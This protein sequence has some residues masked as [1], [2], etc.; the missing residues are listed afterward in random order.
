MEHIDTPPTFYAPADGGRN[1][2]FVGN[3]GHDREGLSTLRGDH[4]D[5]LSGGLTVAVDREHARAL[6]REK[7]SGGAAVSDGGA[8]R[9]SRADDDRD[10]V[11]KPHN[12]AFTLEIPG[13]MCDPGES[14]EQ[15][16]RRELHEETGHEAAAWT[17]LGWV[18]PNPALQNNRCHTFLARDLVESPGAS[19]DPHEELEIVRRP[20][21]AIPDLISRGE[22]THALVVA[23]FQMFDHKP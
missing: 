2:G 5:R 16:A 10:L 8:G 1:A 13:G 20:L 17:E 12:P 23:A 7:Q 3:V 19:P 15:A 21:S 9:L 18:H 11:F 14:P 6:T 22:I 4:L